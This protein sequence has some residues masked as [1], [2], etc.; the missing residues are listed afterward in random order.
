MSR[1]EI[2]KSPRNDAH[3]VVSDFREKLWIPKVWI[4]LTFVFI[5]GAYANANDGWLNV[6]KMFL[7]LLFETIKGLF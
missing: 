2:N 3:L 5:G 4:L 1:G 6:G 7:A